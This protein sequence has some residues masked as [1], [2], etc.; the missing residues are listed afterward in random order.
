MSLVQFRGFAGKGIIK[1][2]APYQLGLDAF[3]GGANVRFHAN[4]AEAAPVFKTA[5]N[6]ITPYPFFV[7]PNSPAS[8]AVSSFL[9]ADDGSVEQLSSGLTQTITPPYLLFPSVAIGG[10]GYLEGSPPAVTV[11]PPAT[12]TSATAVTSVNSAGQV[13]NIVIVDPGSG[14]TSAP[15]LTIAAPPGTATSPVQATATCVWAAVTPAVNT[16]TAATSTALGDVTFLNRPDLFPMYY[17]PSSTTLQMLPDWRQDWSCRS[18]RSYGDYLIAMNVTKTTGTVAQMVKWSDLTL[19]GQPPMSWD[20]NDLTTSAGENVLEDLDTPLVDG[21][22]LRSVFI[23]YSQDSIYEMAQNGTSL[24]FN[25]SRLFGDGGLIAPNCVAEVDGIHY[26]FGASDIYQHDGVSKSSIV[27]IRN[28]DYVF[29]N[30][31]HAKTERFFVYYSQQL[32]CVFF[33]YVD[34]SGDAAF[35]G[36]DYPNRAAVYDITAQTWSFIDLPNCVS[37]YTLSVDAGVRWSS[38]PNAQTWSTW[39]GTWAQ[40]NGQFTET[41]VFASR[42]FSGLFTASRLLAYDFITKG[43]QEGMTANPEVNA[44]AVLERTGV[45][46]DT[47]GSDL[48]TY[49]MVRRVY[50]L[51]SGGPVLVQFGAAQTPSG[52]VSWSP[53]ITYDPVTQYKIDFRKGGRYLAF[54]VTAPL[55][56][57]F[58][59]AGFD[60]DITSAGRR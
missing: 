46:L 57:D 2:P 23:L 8:S 29:N 14:Y 36:T 40:Q 35:Q 55:L 18:L 44:P 30:I 17:G 51:V 6:N 34:I 56:T 53:T 54:R 59:V 5:A 19:A 20:A 41:P 45:D 13:V 28:R 12:G 24:I 43:I 11:S 52:A 16:S 26:C 39:T 27:D 1:D 42:A 48:T 22:P 4:R 37:A 21:A 25:F 32:K 7:A 33:C 50:P 49:K 38:L 47:E 15:T 3:S 9:M 31:D 60:A 10:A 58:S